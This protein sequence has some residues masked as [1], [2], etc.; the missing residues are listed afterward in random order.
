MGVVEITSMPWVYGDNPM[1]RGLL[2]KNNFFL[3]FFKLDC[4]FND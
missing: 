2:Y 1:A 3:V 4:S